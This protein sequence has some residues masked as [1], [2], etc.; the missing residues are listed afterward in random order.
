MIKN[1]QLYKHTGPGFILIELMLVVAIIG[2]LAAVAFPE[3]KQYI[4][5]AKAAEWQIMIAP[6]KEA[7]SR[8][9]D[10]WGRLPANNQTA[11]LPESTAYRS[12]YVDSMVIR[13]G[14][15]IVTLHAKELKLDKGGSIVFF[16][17]LSTDKIERIVSW[18][19][20]SGS[21]PAELAAYK[22]LPTV[23]QLPEVYWRSCKWQ[24][25]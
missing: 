18:R 4:V 11:G 6:V 15:V 10:Y 23:E 13:D 20:Y 21:P 5:R 1:K 22:N 7:I 24:K 14:A 17:E 9:F 2:I 8:Y 19:C 16:P 12:R 25:K 3:Y